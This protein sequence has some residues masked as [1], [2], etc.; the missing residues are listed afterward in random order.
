MKDFLLHSLL[1]VSILFSSFAFAQDDYALPEENFTGTLTDEDI[2]YDDLDKEIENEAFGPDDPQ[3]KDKD[4]DEFGGEAFEEA[5][6]ALLTFD[7]DS[8]VI[9]HTSEGDPYMEIDYETKIEDFEIELLQKRW[10]EKTDALFTA[11]II[12]NLAGNDLFTCKLDILIDTYPANI[13][14]RLKFFPETDEIDAHYQ[15]AVQIK[16]DKEYKERWQSKCTDGV[17]NFNT[18]GDPEKYNRTVLEN[19]TPNLHGLVI[20]D[21]DPSEGAE[22]DLSTELIEILDEDLN[23][24]ITLSGKGVLR[25]DPL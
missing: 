11:D 15:L 25:I 3:N 24:V 4:D 8:Q 23:E 2:D 6:P 1:L 7:F 14:T 9:F 17:S 5:Y 22:I 16:L 12:G 18:E 10:R 13:M 19:I 21:F 20:D